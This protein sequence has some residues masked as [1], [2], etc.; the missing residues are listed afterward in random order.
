[1]VDA[2]I[3]SL[4]EKFRVEFNYQQLKGFDAA[5][6]QELFCYLIVYR[7]SY[8]HRE[9]LATLL[10]PDKGTD[11]AK[12]YLRKA[13]WQL[14]TAVSEP[15]RQEPGFL[16]V[17][18]E[19]VHLNARSNDIQLDVDKFEK[20]ILQLRGIE[21]QDL[22]KVQSHNLEQTL[23]LYRGDLLEGRY[24][25]WCI[26]ERERLQQVYLTALDKMM[27][28]CEVNHHFE[29]G[30]AY[31]AQILR[32][33]QARENT[34]RQ[35]IRLQYLAGNRTGALRQYERCKIILRN[36][37]K[38]QPA[39]S[40]SD[41]YQQIQKDSLSGVRKNGQNGRMP[42]RQNGLRQNETTLTDVYQHLSQL[43]SLLETAQ[44]Q[45]RAQKQIINS[46]RER[47]NSSD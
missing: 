34:H 37:L 30:L 28:Y 22:T 13:L 31:G 7:N 32:L 27:D 6:V 3:V 43:E 16:S 24:Q 33:D 39:Q 2:L 21:G 11:Q 26:L 35:L 8:H 10:W 20:G 12:K 25:E 14:Q 15:F 29:Q 17:D 9:K 18:I 40:T 47:N 46:L 1:M 23:A 5:K 36:V 41:L 19:W 44:K 42:H 4:F 45:I 38:V